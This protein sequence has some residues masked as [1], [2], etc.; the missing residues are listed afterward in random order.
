MGKIIS[1]NQTKTKKEQSNYNLRLII[2]ISLSRE[3]NGT[4]KFEIDAND[5]NLTKLDVIGYLDNVLLA[6]EVPQIEIRKNANYKVSFT[7]FY[8]EGSNKKD[9]KFVISPSVYNKEEIAEFVYVVMML[10]FSRK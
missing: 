7:I 2:N 5:H 9:F 3:L 6:L 8:Y 4:C 1:F 10:F